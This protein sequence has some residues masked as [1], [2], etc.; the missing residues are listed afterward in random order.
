MMK[1]FLMII[2]TGLIVF[3]LTGLSFGEDLRIDGS[4]TVLPIAQKAA[5]VYM[6]KHADT[7]IFVSGSGSGTGIKALIDGTTHIATSSR[8]AKDKEVASGKAKGITLTGHKVALDGIIPVVHISMKINDIT[9]EQLR[10]VYNGKIKSWKELGGPNR[11]ISVVSRDTSS[12][13][14]E[15]WEEK[16]LKG[17]KVRADALLVASNG[18]AVQTIAQNK[19]A[20][21]YIGIGY[22]DKSVKILKVNGKSASPASVRDG[23]WPVARPLFMYTNGKPTGVIGKFIHFMMS[24]EGQKVVNEVKYVSIQ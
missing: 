9:M 12:G 16:V 11:P 15:V 24:A 2:F 5:E 10:D 1:K 8:E 3:S 17:D 23:S 7:R 19:F 13:T 4:T 21:G 6:K 14:Y 22:I 20:I 18:Q